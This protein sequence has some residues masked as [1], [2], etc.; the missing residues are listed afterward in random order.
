MSSQVEHGTV[1]FGVTCG[2]T[3]PGAVQLSTCPRPDQR[4]RSNLTANPTNHLPDWRA[5]MSGKCG[6]PFV[7]AFGSRTSLLT[8]RGE[9]VEIP[10]VGGLH[11][12]YERR[13]A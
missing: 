8:L 2:V 4:T 3:E 12:R 11:H 6:S 9:I 13:A 5:K 1:A 7:D 10:Q